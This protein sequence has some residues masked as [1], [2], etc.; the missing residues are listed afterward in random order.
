MGWNGF[1]YGGEDLAY[2]YRL[3]K[4]L[5]FNKVFIDINN[6]LEIYNESL[7]NKHNKHH[8][9]VSLD[10]DGNDFYIAKKILGEE[11]KPKLFICEYNAIFPPN[12]RWVMKYNSS[13]KWSGDQYFGASLA[14]LVDLF[15]E[16]DYFLCAC[17]PQTG[18]NAFF[19]KSEYR[20]LFPE[21]PE[22]ID[23]I[24][25]SPCYLGINRFSHEISPKFIQAII[26]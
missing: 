19:V 9:V 16:N 12:V 18:S 26:G 4:K 5:K 7:Q 10:L 24:H 2:D 17:N 22:N 14:S 6:I 11:H 8:D 3:S 15:K 20:S 25:V 23:D 21:V 1:W 13:H